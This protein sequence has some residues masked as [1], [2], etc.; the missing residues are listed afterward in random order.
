MFDEFNR[1]I[2]TLPLSLDEKEQDILLY[3][4]AKTVRKNI[5][6]YEEYI[7]SQKS[8]EMAD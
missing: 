3:E 4:Y 5:K 8:S 7:K 1:F 6:Q 2:A